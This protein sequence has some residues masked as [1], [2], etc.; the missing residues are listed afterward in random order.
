MFLEVFE[1]RQLL[2]LAGAEQDTLT[3]PIQSARYASGSRELATGKNTATSV[4][5]EHEK[6]YMCASE[7]LS[8]ELQAEDPMLPEQTYYGSAPEHL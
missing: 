2:V 4:T 3:T 1:G 7:E 6:Y 5:T 8:I